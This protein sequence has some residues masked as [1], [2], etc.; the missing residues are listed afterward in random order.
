MRSP[1]PLVES[2]CAARNQLAVDAPSGLL[3]FEEEAITPE[4]LR[5]REDSLRRQGRTMLS[6]LA[7]TQA[8]DVAAYSD[9]VIP[10]G[11]LPWVYQWGTL[12]RREHRGHRLGL[13]VKARA[14]Q[15]L[16]RRIAPER[17]R[18]HTCNAEQ[19]AHMV[20]INERLGFRKVEVAP[21]FL[22]RVAPGRRTA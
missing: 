2:L 16:Q 20:G 13:A 11:D 21:A 17:T 8:G 6:T 5:Y 19:N 4:L 15:E 7:L 9:L 3:T 1:S 22:L 18:V 10:A 14:L 12:V